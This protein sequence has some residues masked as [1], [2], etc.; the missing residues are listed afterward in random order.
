MEPGKSPVDVGIGVERAKR[1]VH[2]VI[3]AAGGL[4]SAVARRLVD[5]GATVV[6]AGRDGA[7]LDALAA[8]IGADPVVVDATSF[9][10][11]ESCLAGALERHGRLD[12]VVNCAGSL[13]L[14]PAHLTRR[15]EWDAI[16][17]SNLTTAFATVRAAGRTMSSGGSVVLVSSAVAR[18]GLPNHEAV[19]AAKAGVAGLALSAAATYAPRGLRFNAIAPGLMDTPLTARILGSEAGRRASTEM[20]ALGRIGAPAEVA[21]LVAW[22]L[23]PENDWVTGQLFGIDG[24]LATVRAR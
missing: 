1:P 17:A 4:G 21:R 19:A 3:G 24:G 16:L 10:A 15:E 18:T 8:E 9:E 20:H 6:A 14:K 23:D 7:R 22:L 5:A 2:V 13:L 12:G 11:V